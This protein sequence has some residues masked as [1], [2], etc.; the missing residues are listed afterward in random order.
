M[1]LVAPTVSDFKAYF[2]RDFPYGTDMETTVLDSDIQKALDK[3][4]LQ[5]NSKC[6]SDQAE[7]TQGYL[8]LAA[9]YLVMALRTAS[10]GIASSYKGDVASRSVGGV[11][12]SYS[13][14][15]WINQNPL[16]S[17]FTRTGYGNEYLLMILPCL[18]GNILVVDGRTTA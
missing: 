5:I 7:Y 14:P 11:S 1:S 4:A 2:V 6:L 9:H 10:Q 18:V 15:E 12:E 16:Y 3:A 13:I 8:L 17:S